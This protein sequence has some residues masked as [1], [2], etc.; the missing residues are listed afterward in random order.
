M[1]Q[2]HSC[3]YGYIDIA[4]VAEVVANVGYLGR[5]SANKQ[6]TAAGIPLQT[7][8]M[9]CVTYALSPS[10]LTHRTLTTCMSAGSRRSTH[11]AF[12]STRCNTSSRSYRPIIKISSSWSIQPSFRARQ[13]RRSSRTER[14]SVGSS[15]T[16]FSSCPR[17]ASCIKGSCGPVRPCFQTGRRRMR[18][19]GGPTSLRDFSAKRMG[20]M[21][22][23]YGWVCVVCHAGLMDRYE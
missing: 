3:K 18:S 14:I 9:V 4:E 5:K 21:F 10:K 15:K 1:S 17:M 7:Q 16:S 8:W 11:P 12:R 2:F 22:R 23:E 13:T 20:L 19:S 6:Y